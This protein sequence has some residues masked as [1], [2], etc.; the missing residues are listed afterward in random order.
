[1]N[2]QKCTKGKGTRIQHH[3]LTALQP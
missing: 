2:L 1:M 3:S